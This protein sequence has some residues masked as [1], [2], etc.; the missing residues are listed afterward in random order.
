MKIF[1]IKNIRITKREHAFKGFTC[2]Y[3]AEISNS[4]NHELQLKYTELSIKSMLIELLTQSKGLKFVIAL[5]LVFKNIGSEDKT[6]NE[7]FYSRSK[8]EIII[9]ESG[10]DDVF[11]QSIVQL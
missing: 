2:T 11:Q 5:V 3:N 6:K 4:F 7:K 8:A 1:Y 10:I 9:S